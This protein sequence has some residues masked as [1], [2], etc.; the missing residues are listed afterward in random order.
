[1]IEKLAT[2]T[3][4]HSAVV[5]LD[6]GIATEDNLKLISSKGYKYLCISRTKLKDYKP[7]QDRLTVLMETKSG[8]TIRLKSVTTTNHTDYYLEAKSPSKELK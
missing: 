3:C 1:M 8:Q 6:A 2:H 5:V 7:V 4:G